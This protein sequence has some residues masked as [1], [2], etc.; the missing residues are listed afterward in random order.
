[1]RIDRLRGLL[2]ERFRAEQCITPRRIAAFAVVVSLA[3]VGC[4]PKQ[5]IPLDCVPRDV[6]L[7]VDK[8]RVEELPDELVLRADEAHYLYFKREGY[9]PVPVVIQTEEG[10]NG[11]QLTPSNIC[12]EVRFVELER[13][14]E[15]ELE[16]DE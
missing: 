3:S 13:G 7:Y 16:Q 2:A 14:L 5:K 11:P 6:T 4:A 9:Q 12:S 8:E 15:L 1:V 10:E